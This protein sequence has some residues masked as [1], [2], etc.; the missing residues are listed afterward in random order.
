MST[1]HKINGNENVSIKNLIVL[2][3]HMDQ[4]HLFHRSGEIES[5][6][7]HICKY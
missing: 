5:T 4:S 2:T 3:L 7:A 6:R 1:K